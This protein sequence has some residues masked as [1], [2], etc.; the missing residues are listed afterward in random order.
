[1]TK[2][3]CLTAL[4]AGF[5]FAVTPAAARA[6]GFVTPFIGF[7]FGGDSAANCATFRNC[8]ERRLN[9]GIAFGSMGGIFGIEEEIGYAKDFFG[10]TAGGDNAV[11]TAMTNLLLVVV[12][13]GPIQP[14]GLIGIGLVRPHM[15]FDASSLSLG[16][17]ALGHD[18]GGGINIFL[19]RGVGVRGDVRHLQTFEDITLGVF[20]GEKLAFWRASAGL[21]FRF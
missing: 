3:R 14:Y 17:N 2:K 20:S 9:W 12:P 19:T 13:A 18:I 11:L 16:K 15:K 21:T 8:E 6:E 4:V 1:M 5:L 7:N 10:K